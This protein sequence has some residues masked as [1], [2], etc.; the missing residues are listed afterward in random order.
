MKVIVAPFGPWIALE[1]GNHE[2]VSLRQSRFEEGGLGSIVNDRPP[3][4]LLRCRLVP[5]RGP[6]PRI[7]SG[8]GSAV[9]S[10]SG[11]KGAAKIQQHHKLDQAL[12]RVADG[13]GESDVIVEFYDDSTVGGIAFATTAAGGPQ[14]AAAQGRAGRIPNACSSASPTIRRSSAFIT[15]ARSQGEIARTAATVGA[16][17]TAALQYGYTGAGIGVAVI[18]S[19]ITPWHDDLT[20]GH[21]QQD[22]PA[23]RRVRRL[24]QQPDHEVRRLGPRHA[25][26]RHHR[27]QRLRLVRRQRTGDRAEGA[28]SSR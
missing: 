12:N 9:S 19:G 4:R 16:R 11:S 18:D 22:R 5:S 28:T 15:T 13:I 25:R 17:G 2:P 14:A 27:R 24:R 7:S 20:R 23:R 10:G 8:S 26:R 6:A 3:R 1:V 21:R